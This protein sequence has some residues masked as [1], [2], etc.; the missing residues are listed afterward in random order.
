MEYTCIL[1]IQCSVNIL[2]PSHTVAPA[3]R[4]AHCKVDQMPTYFTP[5]GR[6]QFS[7]LGSKA[8][9]RNVNSSLCICIQNGPSHMYIQTYDTFTILTLW[10][11]SLENN[12]VGISNP[13]LPYTGIRQYKSYAT[14]ACR[15]RALCSTPEWLCASLQ[16]ACPSQSYTRSA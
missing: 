12:F 14:R 8:L 11:E 9:V 10:F 1:D 15:N 3:L 16:T 4:L 5:C 7:A 2:I 13:T 6:R